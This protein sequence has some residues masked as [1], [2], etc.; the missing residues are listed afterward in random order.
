[1]PGSRCLSLCQVLAVLHFNGEEPLT[2]NNLA[3]L[4]ATRAMLARKHPLLDAL[5]GTTWALHTR[6]L[7]WYLLANKKGSV[8]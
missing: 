6:H 2:F 4:L 3:G 8:D 1:M 5:L 7:E